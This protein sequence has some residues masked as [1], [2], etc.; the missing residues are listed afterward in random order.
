[1]WRDPSTYCMV[2]CSQ[3]FSKTTISETT[4]GMPSMQEQKKGDWDED[5]S[6]MLSYAQNL[7]S[8]V[9]KRANGAPLSAS[10][11]STELIT[12]LNAFRRVDNPITPS[13]AFGRVDNSIECIW[14]SWL[15]SNPIEYIQPRWK[16]H[17]MHLAKFSTQTPS[18][19]FGR[20]EPHR[21]Y[22]AKWAHKP[23]WMHSPELSWVSWARTPSNAFSWV[24]HANPIEC[25]QPSWELHRMYSAEFCWVGI[26]FENL[27]KAFS[28]V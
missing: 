6:D 10:E 20:V 19:A 12:P 21:M 24:H 11:Q 4:E 7:P 17:W 13:N 8:S 1:M 9:Q 27:I 14:T 26:P 5:E 16:P 18:N 22:A 15:S 2:V 3:L 23:H 28:R 25:I